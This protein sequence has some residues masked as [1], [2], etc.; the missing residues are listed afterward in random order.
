MPQSQTAANPWHQVDEKK[1]QKHARAKQTNM[2]KK[3]KDQ[4]TLPQARWSEC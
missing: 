2:Y 4:L 3:H 1:G